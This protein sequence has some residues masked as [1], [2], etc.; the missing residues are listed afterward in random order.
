[1]LIKRRAIERERFAGLII[2]CCLLISILS[3]L[4]IRLLDVKVT[5]IKVV[6][7]GF[8][9]ITDYGPINI[10]KNDILRIERTY[11]KVAITGTILEQDK[12]Y[13]PKGFI[14]ISQLDPFWSTTG[15]Q[16]LNSVDPKG[17]P[18]WIPPTNNQAG[19]TEKSQIQLQNENLKMIQ[20]FSYAIGTPEKYKTLVFLVLK[21]QNLALAVGALALLVLIF[22]LRLGTSNS[23]S[24]FVQHDPDYRSPEEQL[25]AVAK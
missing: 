24:P 16:L 5:N 22:P 20:Q 25:G 3:M 4:G 18:V 21:L 11:P 10:E 23:A 14:Y 2:F 15:T 13:T 19:E 1:M 17:Y 9:I 7:N 12:I 6:N 8:S